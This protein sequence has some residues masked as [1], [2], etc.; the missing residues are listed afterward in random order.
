MISMRPLLFATLLL[1]T[2]FGKAFGAKALTLPDFLH[3]VQ[4]QSPDLAI[5]RF[6]TD[7]ALARANG[8][9]IPPPMAGLMRMRD[10]GGTNNGFEISQELPF[11]TKIQRE[12]E[13]RENE[14]KSQNLLFNYRRNTILL[15]ARAAYLEFW[16]AFEKSRI[17]VEKRDW[18]KGHLKISRTVARGDSNA[19]IHLLGAESETDLLENEVLESQ[20][21]LAEKA[22]ALRG[23]V[24]DLVTQEIEPQEP[25]LESLQID[26]KSKSG[27]VI[28]KES[29]VK[30]INSLKGLK[31]SAYLP[32]FVV[33]YRAYNGNEMTQRSEEIMV[34]ITLPFFFFWQPQSEVSE[35]SA[36]SQRA[37]AELEKSRIDFEAR[38]ASLLLK[39]ESLKKRLMNLKEKLIPRA[40]KRMRLVENLSVRSIEGLDAHRM[41]MLDYLDLRRKELDARSEF[42][43]AMIEISKLIEKETQP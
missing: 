2:H 28:W 21:E 29:E 31:Q 8:V 16:Q 24:P 25:K 22:G 19:Q 4:T 12:K 17:S 37:Q 15:D 27:L 42:E 10:A 11:P 34:G 6:L 41:V 30:L 9:R 32:D 20:A 43:R 5:E 40:H 14:A 23:F 7:E 33:R 39:S 26:P 36:R 18:L 35:V 1:T 3:R 38:I 13:V